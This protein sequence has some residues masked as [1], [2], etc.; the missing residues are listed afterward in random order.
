MNPLL[1]SDGANYFLPSE[2]EA[3]LPWSAA[4]AGNR[5]RDLLLLTALFGV[6]FG[7]QLGARALWSP[8]EGR[9]AEISREMAVSGDYVTPRLNGV[10]Y[11]EKPPLFYWLQ[12]A[13]IKLL[14]VEEWSLRL[15]PALLAVAGCLAVYLAGRELFGRGAGFIAAVILG[16]S[17]LYFALARI[18]A[19]D[20][21]L[22]IFLTC[23]MLAFLLGTR[24]A[25]GAGRR[26]C[27]WG[28]YIFAALAML[29]KGLVGIVIPGMAIG[30]WSL[31][32]ASWRSLRPLY[33]PSGLCL[34]ALIVMP[35]HYLVS[36][37][38]PEFFEFY[39]IHEHFQRYLGQGAESEGR[40][41]TF[42]PVLALG[43]FPWSAFLFHAVKF[44]FV[45]P[46]SRQGTGH[47]ALFLLVWSA[48]VFV[49]FSASSSQGIP[50]ILP[51]FPPLALLLGR[52]FSGHWH[53]REMSAVQAGYWGLLVALCLLVVLGLGMPQHY[54]E[55]YSNWP[56]LGLPNDDSTIASHSFRGYPDIEKLGSAMGVLTALLLVW[57]VAGY[58]AVI[59][60]RIWLLFGSVATASAVALAVL[61]SSL[62]AL[63]QR[64]SVKQIAEVLR[65]RLQPGDEVA[66]Y[67]AYYQDLPVYLERII[68][69]VGWEGELKFGAQME[70][71]SD[72]IIDDAAFW[73]RWNGTGTVYMITTQEIYERLRSMP[74]RNFYTVAETEYNV[75]LSNRPLSANLSGRVVA[76]RAPEILAADLWS[77]RKK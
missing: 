77:A 12:A 69:V 17:P 24:Q 54:L 61:D 68:T 21:A 30:V 50:Y 1:K 64:R 13:S 3:K 56:S 32:T 63:D 37:A 27:M 39:F 38:N 73:R 9:Y 60:R 4:G 76:D 20:M 74:G 52:F 45:S 19:L 23:A 35:W 72:W 43:F 26:A 70:D 25:P 58:L 65:P 15:W 71:T 49:F 14:G 29:T 10:K 48:A 44:N 41:W 28:L 67:Y 66:T 40:L 34:F 31:A 53:G 47:E 8:I 42:L 2:A 51:M 16:T 57:A 33:A 7:F 62:P 46:R 11:F 59:K 18:V 5:L 36:A 6:L 55:R 75:L 22:A